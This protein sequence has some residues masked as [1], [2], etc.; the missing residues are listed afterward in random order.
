MCYCVGGCQEWCV[1]RVLVLNIWLIVLGCR[2]LAWN[3]RMMFVWVAVVSVAVIVKGG[4]V[5]AEVVHDQCSGGEVLRSRLSA[6]CV[7]R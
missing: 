1:E 2:E 3:A 7:P 5:P 6:G 4:G